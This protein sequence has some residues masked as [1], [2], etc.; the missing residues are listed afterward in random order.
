MIWALFLLSVA[1][2]QD[3]VV[4]AETVYPV[5]SPPISDGIV[6]VRSGKITAVGTA[7]T[8]AIPD[9]LPVVEG[10]VAVPG[11]VDGLSAA[12]LTGAYN[13]GFDQDHREYGK[14]M[15]ELRALDSYNGYDSLVGYLREHGVTTVHT[16]PSPGQIVGARTLI[17]KTRAAGVD[18]VAVN[19]D[20]WLVFTLGDQAS[21]T[22]SRMGAAAVIRQALST[23]VAYQLRRKLPLAD[24]PAT[25]LGNEALVEA[26]QGKRQV[27]VHAHRVRDIRTALR[28]AEEFALNLV[29]LGGA[30]AYLIRDELAAAKIPVL[31][32]PVMLRTWNSAGEAGNASFENAALLA[33]AGVKVGVMSGYESYVPKVRLVLWEAAIAGAY[34]LGF[35]GALRAVT[36]TNAEILGVDGSVGSLEVGKDGDIAVF[37]G[38]PFEYTSHACAVVVEGE[39]V[40]DVCR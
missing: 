34:G 7:D 1:F 38:D 16:G 26:L 35:E 10:A 15:P 20:N 19:R 6:V 21:G 13:K 12:G 30:E 22:N 23:A 5:A 29:I 18:E 39:L 32:G 36:L 2:G 25:D 28:I 37:D 4:K 11:I 9:G 33:E 40:S 14:V 24:R 8:V 31:V 27:A 17:A 3:L